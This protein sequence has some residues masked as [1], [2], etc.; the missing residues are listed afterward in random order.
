MF[1]CIYTPDLPVQA[2]LRQEKKQKAYARLPVVVL[3]G[4]ARMLRVASLNPPARAAGLRM[5]MTK[6]QAEACDGVLIR[7]RSLP[8]EEA[9]QSALLECADS[10][11]PRVESTAP[12]IVTL[13]FDGLQRLFA[14]LR[15]GAESLMRYVTK[16]G[17][18]TQIAV[19]A[20]PDAALHAAI[21]NP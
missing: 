11:S 12:G 6:L 2:V 21:G 8:D 16:A 5:G 4:P 17:L 18:E 9:A 14:S 3:D 1:A 15:E 13:D 7:E 10:F 19:A 20:D